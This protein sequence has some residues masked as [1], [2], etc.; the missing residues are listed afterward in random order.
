MSIN[1]THQGVPIEEKLRSDLS[2]LIEG[3]RASVE[4]NR[5]RNGQ[6]ESLTGVE[7][8]LDALED[9]TQT[10]VYA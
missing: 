8:L 5:E 2:V 3:A 1:I 7:R 6:P 4:Y 10:G 9:E